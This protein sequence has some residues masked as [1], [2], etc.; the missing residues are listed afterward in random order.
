MQVVFFKAEVA[1]IKV[2]V[3]VLLRS[4]AS[5]SEVS[6]HS[7]NRAAILALSMRTM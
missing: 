6:I 1:A 3:E 2:A 4:A 7:D 5:L